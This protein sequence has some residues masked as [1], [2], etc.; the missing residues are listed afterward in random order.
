MDLLKLTSTGLGKNATPDSMVNAYKDSVVTE[1]RSA[2]KTAVVVYKTVNHERFKEFFESREKYAEVIGYT[3]SYVTKQAKAV[4]CYGE[5]M[6][7]DTAFENVSVGFVTELLYIDKE[8]TA[9]LLTDFIQCE[10]LENTDTRDVVRQKVKHYKNIINGGEVVAEKSETT[11][12]IVD[13]ETESEPIETE[14]EDTENLIF[15]GC[16]LTDPEYGVIP[17]HN[18]D[19]IN[20]I[21]E[22]LRKNG[23]EI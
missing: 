21:R 15:H 5:L 18:I 3:K 11:N 4:E 6:K 16:T 22:V 2:W 8:V 10:G 14:N 1:K 23:Y 9:D 7:V 19:V 17:I 12:N 20:E 13:N